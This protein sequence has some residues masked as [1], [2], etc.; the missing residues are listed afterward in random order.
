MESMSRREDMTKKQSKTSIRKG[1]C[2]SCVALS[3]LVDWTAEII[4][5]LVGLNY[6]EGLTREWSVPDDILL[7]K[8]YYVL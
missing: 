6:F 7:A 2:V 4:Y 3:F 5:K 8:G 1:F